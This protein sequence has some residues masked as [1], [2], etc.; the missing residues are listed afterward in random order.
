MA[1]ESDEPSEQLFSLNSM[2]HNNES[3]HEEEQKSLENL[4]LLCEMLS[5]TGKNQQKERIGL[6]SAESVKL[7]ETKLMERLCLRC[8]DII[9]D[10]KKSHRICL[11]AN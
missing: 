5:C 8:E 6:M 1:E 9:N 3:N 7:S 11:H 4:L 2:Y 10:T